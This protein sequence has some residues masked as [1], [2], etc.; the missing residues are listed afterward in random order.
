MPRDSGARG[1]ARDFFSNGGRGSPS[2]GSPLAGSH[3]I[4]A[5]RRPARVAGITDG[6]TDRSTLARSCWSRLRRGLPARQAAPSGRAARGTRRLRA[7]VATLASPEFAGRRGEGG[8][9]RPSTSSTQFRALGLEPLFDG[10]FTPADPRARPASL[11]SGRNVG[12]LL[13]RRRPEAPRRV[14]HRLGP[15]RPPG[16][17]RRSRSTRAPTTT[18]RASP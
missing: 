4:P 2:Q 6:A 17:P 9:R 13:A 1:S 5:T 16:R 3:P 14:D 12:A 11:R 8:R 18:P 15:F 10:Q 7:H